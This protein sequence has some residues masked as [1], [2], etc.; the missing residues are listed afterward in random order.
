MSGV[1][2]GETKVIVSSIVPLLLSE[3]HITGTGGINFHG[4]VGLLRGSG[5]RRVKCVKHR[6]IDGWMELGETRSG[7]SM[8]AVS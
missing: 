8:V 3:R 5:S 7:S 2:T 1:A 4:H 6:T